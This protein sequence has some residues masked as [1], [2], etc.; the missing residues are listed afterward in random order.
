MACF[1]P[2]FEPP[3]N[4]CQ[5]LG[6]L[7]DD[8]IPNSFPGF[9]FVVLPCIDFHAVLNPGQD[10]MCDFKIGVILFDPFDLFSQNLAFLLFGLQL[11]PIL[12][13]FHQLPL[14]IRNGPLEL[15]VLGD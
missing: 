14:Q 13:V 12:G 9:L 8:Y 3:F 2:Y 4:Q 11:G 10:I 5:P 15:Q 6:L 1:F 7:P